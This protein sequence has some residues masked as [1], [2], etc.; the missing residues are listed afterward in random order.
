MTGVRSRGPMV[1]G[2]AASLCILVLSQALEWLI[3]REFRPDV[4][5]WTWVSDVVVSAGLFVM[6]VLWIHLRQTRAA[7]SAMERERVVID[8]QLSIAAQVQRALLPAIPPPSGCIEWFGVTEPAG[9]VGGDYFDFLPLSGGRMCVVLADVSGKGIAAAIFLSN[10][11]AV[12]HTLIRETTEPS[13]LA[14]RL[15]EALAQDANGGMY[16]S[17]VIAVV[18]P[19]AH[20]MT[21]TNTGHPAGLLLRKGEPARTLTRGGPPAGLMR[22]T[23][24]EEETV[25]LAPGDLV[26]IVSDGITESLDASGLALAAIL[27]AVFE[28]LSEVSPAIACHRLLRAAEH[29]A[30]P[31]GVPDWAD[32]K[33]VVAFGG[34]L[35]SGGLG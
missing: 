21:Y 6:T 32:D 12:L 9:K 25:S 3:N 2:L 30:G 15:S 24:Y 28:G 1:L 33:T 23:T 13:L 16:V 31:A 27:P 22:G 14:E 10:V 11:R 8:T 20:Q 18:D 7:L 35:A 5:E 34:R 29:G 4:E 17:A 26:V 19:A